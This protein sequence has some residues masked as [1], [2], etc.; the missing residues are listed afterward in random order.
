MAEY[1][2]LKIEQDGATAVLSIY[3]NIDYKPRIMD[4]K[5]YSWWMA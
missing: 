3:N 4:Q 1:K 5:Y 2:N